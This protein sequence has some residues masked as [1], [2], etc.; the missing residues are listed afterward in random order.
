MQQSR[1]GEKRGDNHSTEKRTTH[2][3]DDQHTIK[4]I[5]VSTCIPILPLST[6]LLFCSYGQLW[7]GDKPDSQQCEN[8]WRAM[9]HTTSIGRHGGHLCMNDNNRDEII[10]VYQL[11]NEP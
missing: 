2:R 8:I 10:T 4:V 6:L 3:A 5:I 7:V 11:Y 1:R 9:E